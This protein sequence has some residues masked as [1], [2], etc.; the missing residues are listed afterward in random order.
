MASPSA[1]AAHT[2]TT[3]TGPSTL[4]RKLYTISHL[5]IFSFLGTLARL[6]FQ[7]WQTYPGFPIISGL[8]LANIAGCLAMGVVTEARLLLGK[9]T[10]DTCCERSNGQ[11]Q[12]PQLEDGQAQLQNQE[13]E[14]MQGLNGSLVMPL[15]IIT[16]L[17]TL[18]RQEVTNHD[19]VDGRLYFSSTSPEHPNRA[20]EPL[21]P[22]SPAAPALAP[23][24][25]LVPGPRS[26]SSPEI[27]S[28]AVISA[29]QSIPVPLHIGLTTGFCGSL[30][31]FSS[32]M[33]EVF[34]AASDD[35]PFPS[36]SNLPANP[37][38]ST[39]SSSSTSTSPSIPFPL[40]THP[41][42]P[43][44][45][46]SPGYRII[47]VLTL[48]VLTPALCICALEVGRHLA[49]GFFHLKAITG[50]MHPARLLPSSF[51]RRRRS[52]R[53]DE[54]GRA[55]RAG[56]RKRRFYC[57]CCDWNCGWEKLFN[58]LVI[59]LAISTW[60]VVIILSIL[61]S[62]PPT[63]SPS[64]TTQLNSLG[65]PIRRR[66]SL[67]LVLV[68]SPVGCLMRYWISAHLNPLPS[69][70]PFPRQRRRYWPFQFPFFMPKFSRFSRFPLGTFIV[71]I[72]G[73]FIL[74]ILHFAKHTTTTNPSSSSF[75]S[76]G[77]S[78]SSSTL[79]PEKDILRCQILQALQDGFCACLTTVSTWIFELRSLRTTK[80]QQAYLYASLTM[81]VGFLCLVT[82]MGPVRWSRPGGRWT[83]WAVRGCEGL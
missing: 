73:T 34:F 35:P 45:T 80:L 69:S 56:S 43:A 62:Q 70:P 17:S 81:F 32:Y 5:I 54:S 59:F 38:M 48:L 65:K 30:T 55:R 7:Q 24:P 3:T 10:R 19:R 15:K 79:N 53:N 37:S 50:R 78:S 27:P 40:S 29:K 57:W 8:L 4:K 6:G 74:G 22:P 18:R 20:L 11:E 13:E 44:P 58:R 42:L 72:L 12:Q 1:P 14:R 75:S 39:A 16:P 46:S 49:L 52:D 47:S 28:P 9:T 2:T 21:V 41:S 76:S 71:N 61:P 66:S 51:L 25:V 31:S 83:G 68:F 77:N 36:Y 26:A 67:S 64:H 60:L 63:S 33:L 23:V 82:V